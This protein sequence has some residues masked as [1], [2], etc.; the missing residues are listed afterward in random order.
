M[1][2]KAVYLYAWDL[3]DEGPGPV[4]D[5]L[6]EA[7]ADSIALAVSYHAGKFIRPH[8]VTGKVYFPDDGTVYFRH[9]PARYRRLQPIPHPMLEHVDPLAVLEQ[10]APDLARVA[11]TVCCHNTRLGQAHPELVTRNAMGDPLIYS[12]NPA[13]HEVRDYLVDLT[14][15]LATRYALAAVTLETP[16][17]LPYA[18]GYHH[19]FAMLPLD[20]WIELYLGLCF[21]PETVAAAKAAGI[22]ADGLCKR[23]AGR[24]EAWLANDVAP[25]ERAAEWL[26]ADLVTDSELVAYLHWRCRLVADLVGEI[27]AALPRP[28]ELRVI[29]SVQ[30]PTAKSWIEGSDLALLAAAADRLEVCFYEPTAAAVR[31]DLFDVR[32]R[33][34][35]AA[36]L[37]AVLR[38]TYPDLAGG[39]ETVA[40]VEAL[41]AGGVEGLAFYAYG[42][43]RPT[44]LDQVKAGFAA[45]DARP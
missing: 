41:K 32:Q 39:A 2:K 35:E 23:V 11:W 17:W 44:A 19:E 18:H 24:I 26:Q 43:W 33:I 14:R 10:T 4:T 8:G 9:D 42:H 22:D 27:R 45:W 30:R 16:G 31:D 13:H 38:P 37:D 15:D 40:A 7:G 21:A 29:P 5:R 6:R 12:L 1:P 28:T 25:G 3:V 36:P 34:G 20:P